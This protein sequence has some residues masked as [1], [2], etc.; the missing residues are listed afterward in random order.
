MEHL[1]DLNRFF[2]HSIEKA[3]KLIMSMFKSMFNF[4]DKL[5]EEIYIQVFVSS[6]V[7]PVPSWDQEWHFSRPLKLPV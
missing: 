5:L 7:F 6:L 4:F 2:L 1:I 3:E